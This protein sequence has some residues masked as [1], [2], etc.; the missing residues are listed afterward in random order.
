MGRAA[1]NER[2]LQPGEETLDADLVFAASGCAY[3]AQRSLEHEL[4]WAGMP[5]PLVTGLRNPQATDG[6]SLFTL[7]CRSVRSRGDG[8]GGAGRRALMAARYLLRAVSL[9]RM[10]SR[11]LAFLD[12]HPLLRACVASDPRVQERHL[13]RFVNRRWHRADRLAALHT[14]YRLLLQRWPAPL[15]EAVHVHGHATLGRLALR[16]GRQLGL[17]LRRAVRMDCE[18]ELI[19]ELGEPDGPPLYRLVLTVI[20]DDTLAIGGI[21]GPSG[22]MARERARE[23]TRDMHGM[24]PRQLLLALAY[25]LA[26][27]LGLSRILAV[28]HAAHPLAGQ[29]M[30]ADDDSAWLDEGGERTPAGWFLM[31][32]ALRHRTEFEHEGTRREQ[33][34]RRAELRWEAVRLLNDALRPGPWWCSRDDLPRAIESPSSPGRVSRAA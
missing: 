31:P 4:P 22:D 5:D 34:L 23:L 29:R 3:A 28:G 24:R 20:D 17:Q 30:F 14:H 33:F 10:H 13:H 26:G 19:I 12:S 25:A 27:Q 15:F 7:W 16:D 1:L 11:F 2:N 18:G 21:Q 8:A 6:N 32:E 9:P